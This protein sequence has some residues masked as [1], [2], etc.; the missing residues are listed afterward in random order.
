M[1]DRTGVQHIARYIVDG[2]VHHGRRIA[3]AFARLDA[4]PWLGGRE[5]GERDPGGGVRLLAPVVPTKVVCVGLNYRAHIAES[6][7]VAPGAAPPREP[8]LFLKPP[9]A[10]IATGEPI[11]YPPSVTRLDPEAELAVVIGRRATRVDPRSAPDHIAGLT[12]FNDVSARNHQR[13]DGQWTRAKGFD[14]FAPLGP[15]VATGL[16]PGSLTVVCRVNGVER[17]SGRT[18]DLLFPVPEL[19]SFIS[20]VMTLEPGDVIATGTPAGIAPV[21]VGDVIEVEVEGI[22]VLVNRVAG[23]SS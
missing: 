16:D 14:T 1:S 5:T 7:S 6:A 19:V 18:S 17:Q 15:W 21:G 4:P 20:G 3:E 13:E 10:V 8:L 9:S 12:C 23:P 11:R 2:R 22:G